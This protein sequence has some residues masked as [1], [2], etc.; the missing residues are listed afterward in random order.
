MVAELV[1]LGPW[2][3]LPQVRGQS[4]FPYTLA[5]MDSSLTC[6]KGWG[7]LYQEQNQFSCEGRGWLSCCSVQ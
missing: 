5:I 2:G 6:G 7:H 1:I 3:H 4:Q